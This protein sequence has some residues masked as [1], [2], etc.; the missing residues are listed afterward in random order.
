MMPPISVVV[1]TQRII[2]PNSMHYN[3]VLAS[4]SDRLFTKAGLMSLDDME[5]VALSEMQKLYPGSYSLKVVY[6][7]DTHAAKF[8]LMFNSQ[9]DET[10][11]KLKYEQ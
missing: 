5:R 11:F 9:A 4:L 3:G 2:Y 8:K 6:D 10:F 7:V 1:G